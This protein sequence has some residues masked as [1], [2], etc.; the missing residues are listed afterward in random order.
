[1]LKADFHKNLPAGTLIP[2][3]YQLEFDLEYSINVSLDMARGFDGTLWAIREHGLVFNKEGKWEDEPMPSSRNKEFFT[4]C[5]FSSVDEALEVWFK[6][7]GSS[8]FLPD[9]VTPEYRLLNPA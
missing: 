4:R 3:S 1:M 5:R 8:Y 7:E 6:F 9:N 2:T